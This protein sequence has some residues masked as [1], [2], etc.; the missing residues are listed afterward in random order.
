[1]T[2]AL[3]GLCAPLCGRTRVAERLE[4]L[5]RQSGEDSASSR[6]VDLCSGG[7]G[8]LE[9]VL[10]DLKRRGLQPRVVLTDKFPNLA[11]FEAV[12]KRSKGSVEYRAES[13]DATRI[14][15]DLDGVRTLFA[16]FHHFDDRDAAGILRDA[17]SKGRGLAIFEISERHPIMILVMPLVPLATLFLTPFLRPFRLGRLIF[18]YLVPV[19]PALVFWDGAVS[20]LRTRRPAEMQALADRALQDAACED[21]GR[22]YEFTAGRDRVRGLPVHVTWLVGCPRPLP[23]RTPPDPPAPPCRPRSDIRRP[24]RA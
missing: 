4:E 2:D 12:R 15:E 17:A 14:P 8:A 20:C 18:T 22:G 11:T 3:R 21:E 13:V 10:D 1:M 24:N 16:S 9:P 6:I 5:L 23:V 19:V 7:T